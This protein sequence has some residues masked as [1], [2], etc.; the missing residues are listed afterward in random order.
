[1]MDNQVPFESGR[2]GGINSHSTVGG[3]WDVVE[4][5]VVVEP[6][7]DDG[8]SLGPGTGVTSGG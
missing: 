4:P 5:E 6:A 7:S 8:E 2:A 3:I 1:M